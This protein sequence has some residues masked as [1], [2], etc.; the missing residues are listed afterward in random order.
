[1]P[2]VEVFQ[3]FIDALDRR[4]DQLTTF[5]PK[6]DYK[7][8]FMQSMLEHLARDSADAR[9]KLV[10]ATSLL[11]QWADEHEASERDEQRYLNAEV[12]GVA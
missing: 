6:Y 3:R 2:Q 1:M 4:S 10:M 5:D 7:A 12:D 8:G 9:A 11:E